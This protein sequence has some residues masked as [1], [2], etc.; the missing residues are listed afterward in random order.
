MLA[1][2]EKGRQPLEE[3][4]GLRFLKYGKNN[5]GYWDY[6]M[7]ADQVVA[8]LDCI[9]VLY[10]GH[11]IVLDV[12]AGPREEIAEGPVCL[13]RKSAS[14][15]EERRHALVEHHG[16]VPGERGARWENERPGRAEGG[17]RAALRVLKRE[18]GQPA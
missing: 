1:R 12:D 16:G 14:R 5:E 10:P 4:P 11:Q 6:D 18:Q 3:S 8:L 17:R 13:R 2:V 9:E 7:F 15:R